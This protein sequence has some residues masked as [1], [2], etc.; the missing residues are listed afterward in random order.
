MLNDPYNL[1]E[2]I[3]NPKRMVSQYIDEIESGVHHD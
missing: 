3:A 1:L 2:V